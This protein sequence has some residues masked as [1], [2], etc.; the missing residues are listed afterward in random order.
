MLEEFITA[1]L[2]M[3]IWEANIYIRIMYDGITQNTDRLRE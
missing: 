1:Y 3:G 2:L